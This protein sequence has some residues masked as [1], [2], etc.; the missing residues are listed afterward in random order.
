[1]R[2]GQLLVLVGLLLIAWSVLG[3]FFSFEAFNTDAV[4]NLFYLFIGLVLTWSGMTWNPEIRRSWMRA[5]GL[6]FT[7]LAL[8]GWAVA[9]R[10]EPNIWFTNLESPAENL[11]HLLLGLVFLLSSQFMRSDEVYTEPAGTTRNLRRT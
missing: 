7:G 9:G 11:A 6:L 4:H 8:I 3:W 1:M 5:V 2:L 10:G